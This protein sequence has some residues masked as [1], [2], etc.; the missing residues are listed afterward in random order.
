MAI[1]KTSLIIKGGHLI[2]PGSGLNETKDILIEDGRIS[3]I[4]KPGSIPANRA[5]KSIDAKGKWVV[6][7][8]ID[9]HVH[10]REPGFEYKETISTGT[11]AA[12]AGGFTSV[13]CM[14]NTQPVNDSRHVT[15]FIR[16]RAK[17]HA[18]CRVFPIGAVSR[19]LRG[20]ELAEIGGMVEEGAVAIS[21]DGM[22]VMNSYLM[23]KA[24]DYARAFSI[25]VISHAEDLNLVGKGV[26]N[27]GIH[28]TR[29]GLRG[30]PAASEEILVAREV[31]LARLTGCRVHIAHL[32]TQV[33]IEHVRRA[34]EEGL[35]ITAEVT[36]HHLTLNDSHLESYD[37][38][39]KMAPPLRSEVDVA[40]VTEALA[41]GVIDMIA[42][43]HAPHGL[44]DKAV[45]FDHAV[46]GVLG[47]Q[48]AV[49]VTLD[50]VK[51]GKISPLRWV[52]SLTYLPAKLINVPHGTLA[53]GADADITLID[54]EL[55]WKWSEED[56][57]SKSA[58]S[59]FQNREFTGKATHTVLGGQI[60]YG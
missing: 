28:S 33:G 19:G 22:P 40:A 38:C 3:A 5:A 26:M 52:E 34:K 11:Q 39:L 44:I 20:E 15:A 17:S 27:E 12:I 54:P 6:P 53:I 10:L 60:V 2:D 58:N 32:S 8:L 21:D 55:K 16:E 42:T 24:M 51:S 41:T 59:P 35:H 47:L 29:L 49:G 36:P 30:I 45:E 48:T 18:A 56:N 50:L 25:P 9:V 13:A 43:D 37:T 1:E 23:R 4:D 57:R 31:A 46:C 14:A 7:G